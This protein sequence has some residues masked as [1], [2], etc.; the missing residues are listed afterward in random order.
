MPATREGDN[1]SR[2]E[3]TSS[4]LETGTPIPRRFTCDGENVSPPLSWSNV[5]VETK[6]FA[7]I[8]EDP[9]A[10]KGTFVHW[11]LYN[12]PADSTALKPGVPTDERLD[13][14]A[15]QGVNGAGRIGFTGPCPPRGPAHRYFFRVYALDIRLNLDV[16]PAAADLRAAMKGHVLAEGGLM[17][18]YQR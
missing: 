1:T 10:P 16:T 18:T 2:L 9:D 15:S 6:S 12:L 17:G 14:G 11:V 7:M 5:P 4:A 8:A 3:V 13:S